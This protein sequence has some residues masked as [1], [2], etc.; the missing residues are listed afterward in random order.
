MALGSMK[1]SRC[2]AAA[3]LAFAAGAYAADENE[4]LLELGAQLRYVRAL[5]QGA[6]INVSCPREARLAE[7]HGTSK[8]QLLVHL[9][10]PDF[11]EKNSSAWYWSY[12]LTS[13]NESIDKGE[14]LELTVGGGFPIIRF[15]FDANGITE[16]V[17]CVYA[18]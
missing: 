8:E 13:P 5:P 14:F 11:E 9:S 3:M 18:R 1:A 4:A 16:G 12:F 7:L 15:T 2:I 6:D 17:T 10:E